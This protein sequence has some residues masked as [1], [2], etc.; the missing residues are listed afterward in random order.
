VKSIVSGLV[1]LL[2]CGCATG[3]HR[4]ATLVEPL[5]DPRIDQVKAAAQECS[6]PKVALRIP[7]K[8][9]KYGCFCGAN[10][11][12]LKHQSAVNDI[13]LD[14]TQR[15][16]LAMAYYSIRPIDDIDAACQAHDVCW[17]LNGEG[18]GKCNDNLARRMD[19][20]ETQFRKKG[21]DRCEQLAF[22]IGYGT[23]AAM[24]WSKDL[25]G[26]AVFL[27]PVQ[28]LFMPWTAINAMGIRIL[29]LIGDGYPLVGERCNLEEPM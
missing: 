3:P 16:E 25:E 18:S 1:L 17:L 9:F 13:E 15:H 28:Y 14:D 2:I 21:D 23:L 22:D 6:D 10:H 24:K 4:G 8:S 5:S 11:P 20:I 7:S 12:G 26:D 19:Y 29:G 27:T